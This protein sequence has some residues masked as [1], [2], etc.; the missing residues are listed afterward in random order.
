MDIFKFINPVEPTRLEQG[1]VINRLKSKM[2]IE[3]YN[4]NGDFELVANANTGLREVLPIGS[5]I[6][7]VDSTEVMIVE[8]HAISD[9]KGSE[10]EIV[11]TG[12]GF[13]TFFENRIVGSNK[14]FPTSNGVTDYSLLAANTWNQAVTLIEDHILAVNLI[15]DD[16]SIPYTEVLTDVTGTGESVLREVKREDLYSNLLKILDV[17]NLGVKVIRPGSWS[18]LAAG[19]P[20]IAVLIRKGVDRTNEVIFSYDTGEIE[21]AD[22]VWSNKKLKNTAMVSG[23]WV[24]T[25]VTTAT[26]NYDRRMMHVNASDIDDS[27]ETAPTGTDLDDVV[28]AMQARG[29]EALAAQKDVALTKAEVSKDTNTAAYRTDFDVGDLITVHG[30]YNETATRRISEYVEIEDENGSNGY[31]TL[32]VDNEES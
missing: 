16:D 24:E 28:A 30:D 3:R 7:H 1:E 26:T 9:D 10:P 5:L 12:R 20:N 15:D 13:E 22:Y 19:S 17:D 32:T 8:S 2:W 14:T 29:N 18:P 27:Y 23:K 21:S 31:P 25:L 4:R 6:S 11:V